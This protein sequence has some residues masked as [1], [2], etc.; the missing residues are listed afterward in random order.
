[1]PSRS[2]GAS[3][4]R[5]PAPV[6][7]ATA[8]RPF[9]LTTAID[10]A[11]GMPHLGHALEKIEADCVARYR[12][13][14]G[15]VHFVT[16]LDEHGQTVARTAD[17]AGCAPQGW[18]DG[19]AAA[20][21]EALTALSISFDDFIRTTEP[22]HARAVREVLRRI[23]RLQPA[24]IY[25]APCSGFYCGGCET[26]K[27]SHELVADHC[28]EHP[29]ID[30]EWVDERA[31]FFRLSAYAERLRAHYDAH[32]HFVVPPGKFEEI[33]VLVSRELPDVAISRSQPRWG[34]P[35]PGAPRH[36]VH[37]WFDALVN[38]LSATGFPNEGYE[39]LWPADL[40]LIGPDITRFHA[41]V[42][43]AMLMAAGLELP[44]Q[45]WAHGWLRADGARF[46]KIAGVGVT[47][48]EAIAR[49][50]PDVLRYYLLV[51]MPWEGDGEFSWGRFDAVATGV[52]DTLE[53][54]VSRA[55]TMIVGH[56]GG[57]IPPAHSDGELDRAHGRVLAQY[58]S[59]MDALQLGEGARQLGFLGSVTTDYLDERAR[60]EVA[61]PGTTAE[62]DEAVAAVHRALV[63]IAA[64]AQPFMPGTAD[65]LYR[66]L[67]GRGSIAELG[68]TGLAH[69]DTSGW[70]VASGEQ[71]FGKELHA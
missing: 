19:I 3:T 5:S 55:V 48:E 69:P 2:A 65:A 42:W 47:L 51:S 40:Q 12:R 64:L 68:W 66:T 49:H 44:Q 53:N 22:R 13:L 61:A 30:L 46:S 11:N 28:A 7:L 52:A 37:V 60:A 70:Q 21:R 58:R 43:P 38:Y 18:V 27:L 29:T 71:L 10:Y 26:F 63:R 14:G 54:L 23:R 25:V 56:N 45:V 15:H 31:Y 39:L 8:A 6:R 9:Y 1:L 57:R 67:G 20:Y 16:G 33:R 34:I 4:P 50:G 62:A 59:A 17:E 41:V 32:P 36:T 35:F 24:D